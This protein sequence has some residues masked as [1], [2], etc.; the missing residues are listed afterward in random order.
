M[1]VT[2]ITKN[3]NITLTKPTGTG[4]GT[5][6]L[7]N[8]YTKQ[9]IDAMLEEVDGDIEQLF[10][11][12]EVDYAT[13]E[14][15][16]EK[17]AA[18]PSPDLSNYAT[19]DEIPDVSNFAT[20]DEIP[21]AYELPTATTEA[22]GGVMVDGES[23]IIAEDGTISGAGKIL[24]KNSTNGRYSVNLTGE[25]NNK[26]NSEATVVA[27]AYNTCNG[28]YGFV[29][30]QSNTGNSDLIFIAG[31][32][33]TVGGMLGF[34]QG[35]YHSISGYRGVAM[36]DSCVVGGQNAFAHGY[37]SKASSKN[38]F[39]HGK[40]NVDDT[41]ETYAHIVGNGTDNSTRSN[42]YTLDWD[43]NAWFAGDV[44]IG[45]NNDALATQA[46]VDAAIAAIVDGEAVSY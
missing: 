32:G 35:D 42:A 8:Y 9:Q 12:L 25:S 4:G 10:N 13:I 28:V 3:G 23:I 45:A 17:I 11:M 22:L 2:L 24:N 7:S 5:V 34:A 44:K 31:R 27:G 29:T 39:V 15:V 40:Y 46:Y 6:D 26:T 33:C 1:G 14:L 38:Q 43:G 19:K 21:D 41:A 16:E 18:I 36:G 30:G 37:G 20:K